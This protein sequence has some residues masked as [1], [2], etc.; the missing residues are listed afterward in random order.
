MN[1]PDYKWTFKGE[2]HARMYLMAFNLA[3]ELLS[4]VNEEKNTP[5]H[6]AV[7]LQRRLAEQKSRV[8][9]LSMG[10]SIL[11]G[12][13]IEGSMNYAIRDSWP[14][15]AIKGQWRDKLNYLFRVRSTP[16]AEEMR[17]RKDLVPIMNA[18]NELIHPKNQFYEVGYEQE[19][20]EPPSTED[21]SSFFIPLCISDIRDR[22][23]F[24][25]LDRNLE[26]VSKFMEWATE[27]P[28]DNEYLAVHSTDL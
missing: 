15:E 12:A 11:L 6:S 4:Q 28:I 3:N 21:L 20:P 7:D 25:D 19:K 26:V 14:K 5:I 22:F 8:I 9:R 13:A 18:R 10:A 1:K 17:I 16:D 2:I 23:H 27:E 24:D